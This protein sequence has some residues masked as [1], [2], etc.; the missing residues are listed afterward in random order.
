MSDTD[1]ESEQVDGATRSG[2]PQPAGLND[3]DVP[4]VADEAPG[5]AVSGSAGPGG[6]GGVPGDAD[7]GGDGDLGGDEDPLR[8]ATAG[9][10]NSGG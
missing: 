5:G 3:P 2:D 7:L 10:E 8:T 4:G 6:G 9:G 1:P